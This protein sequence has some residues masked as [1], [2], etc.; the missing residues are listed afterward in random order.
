MVSAPRRPL[1][2]RIALVTGASRGA[3][4]GIACSL[5]DAGATVYVTAR[6]TRATSTA[7]DIGGTV[8]DVAAEV[9][10]R[11]GTGI[12]VAADHT[13]DS[14]TAAVFE[15]ITRDR[16]RLDLLVNSVWGGAELELDDEPF[17]K[18][19]MGHWNGMFNA[20]VRATIACSRAAAPIMI[21][22]GSGLICHVSFWDRDR[23]TANLFYDVAKVAINRLAFSMATELSSKG[24]TVVAVSPGFM[25][26]ERVLAAHGGPPDRSESPEYVGRAIAALTND[27]NISDKSGQILTAGALAREYEF[28]DIDGSQPPPFQI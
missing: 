8:D 2:D 12:A 4:R 28:T 23:Y 9:T 5:G 17:W 16:G 18:Q 15:R 24:V 10:E 19:P 11:G 13:D 7:P 27:P 14:A 25:R 26:T 20:G 22:Q 3:G 1:A 6:S 21:K